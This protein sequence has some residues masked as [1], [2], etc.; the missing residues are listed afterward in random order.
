MGT[1]GQCSEGM[2]EWTV[3]RV[4]PC[5]LLRAYYGGAF[6]VRRASLQVPA[7]AFYTVG[8]ASEER[9]APKRKKKR[10]RGEAA[11]ALLVARG[12]FVPLDE[13]V[14][15][16]LQAAH[17]EVGSAFVASDFLP[18]WPSSETGGSA[19]GTLEPTL[20]LPESDTR[21]PSLLSNGSD[22][23]QVAAVAVGN[24]EP[25]PNGDSASEG[26]SGLLLLPPRACFATADVRGLESLGLA[27]DFKWVVMDPPWENKSVDR[28][29]RYATFHHEELLRVD[30]PRLAHPEACVLAVWVTNKPAYTAFLLEQALPKWGFTL[31]DTWFWLKL[32]ANG[33]LVTPLESTHRLPFEKLIV[34]YRGATEAARARLRQLLGNQT[35]VITSVPLRHSW[36]PPPE[37]FFPAGVMAPG[38]KKI[39][40]FARELRPHWTS[41]GLEV[42]E[43]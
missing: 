27:S 43:D 31:H 24:E 6:R 32:S 36:K 1:N 23:V 22:D 41:V 8:G 29:R 37:S 5:E 4:N 2:G 10:K 19:A 26:G 34:A 35:R 21:S 15:R 42:S 28:A 40:L 7:G 17:D 18:E 39:E 20:V 13:R 30:V 25:S 11:L 33:E 38:D 12:K 3:A 9:A 14:R 16:T